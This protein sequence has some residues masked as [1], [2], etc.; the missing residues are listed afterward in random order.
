MQVAHVQADSAAHNA[1]P[2][3]KGRRGVPQEPG[4]VGRS[5]LGSAR[6]ASAV[7][8]ES[9]KARCLSRH[10]PVSVGAPREGA[11][12]SILNQKS[13]DSLQGAFALVLAADTECSRAS[14]G[15]SVLQPRTRQ[16]YS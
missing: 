9:L 6:R 13:V 11:E 14:W 16:C 10:S 3:V 12:T 1:A 4:G 8:D 2:G 15:I 5:A 7:P